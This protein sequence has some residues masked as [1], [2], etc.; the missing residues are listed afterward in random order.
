MV[1]WYVVTPPYAQISGRSRLSFVFAHLVLVQAGANKDA[2]S[3]VGLPRWLPRLQTAQPPTKRLRGKLLGW[4][5]RGRN[6]Q[7]ASPQAP[8]SY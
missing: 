4:G 5:L 1:Y 2:D 6:H 3:T 7:R 8:R